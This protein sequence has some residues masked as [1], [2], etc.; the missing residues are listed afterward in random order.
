MCVCVCLTD[1]RTNSVQEKRCAG[2]PR[3]VRIRRDG[4]GDRDG[5]MGREVGDVTTTRTRARN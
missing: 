4:D 2:K 1:A 3:W 5:M